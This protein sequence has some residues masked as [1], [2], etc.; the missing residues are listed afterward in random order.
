MK[1]VMLLEPPGAGMMKNVMLLEPPGAGMMDKIVFWEPPGAGMMENVMFLS[2]QLQKTL[3]NMVKQTGGH[4]RPVVFLQPEAFC[5]SILMAPSAGLMDVLFL[6]PSGAGMMEKVVFLEPA[7]AGMMEN[8]L[9]WE[10]PGVGMMV[11]IMFLSSQLQETLGNIVKQTGCHR[12]PE[13]F[14]KPQAFV[15]QC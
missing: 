6:E 8:V 11:N 14:F 1:N 10:P 12:R 7:I 3:E 13:V 9:S 15:H 4:Q 2:S 5:S